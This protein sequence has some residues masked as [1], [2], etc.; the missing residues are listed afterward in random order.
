MPEGTDTIVASEKLKTPV[1]TMPKEDDPRG[2]KSKNDNF[3]KMACPYIE[4]FVDLNTWIECV[5]A[6]SDTTDIPLAKQ[7]FALS[8]ELPISSKRYGATLREDLYKEIKPSSLTK[9]EEGVTKILGFMKERF[10]Q[11]TDEEIYS[12]YA[13]MKT[14]GRKKGQTVCDYIIEYDKM[15]QKAKQLKINN[16]N[17]RVLA[18]DLMINANLTDTEFVMIRTVADIRSEDNKRYTSIKQKM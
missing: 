15:L 4:D 13:N 3:T 11:N 17:D 1:I 6:W 12:T 14:I 16:T 9:N 2:E 10:W 18:M 8:L 5:E 7:G